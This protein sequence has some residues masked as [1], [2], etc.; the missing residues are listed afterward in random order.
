MEYHPDFFFIFKLNTKYSPVC[1]EGPVS[2]STS[3][4]VSTLWSSSVVWI[5]HP[6]KQR[7]KKNFSVVYSISIFY[8]DLCVADIFKRKTLWH[9]CHWHAKIWRHLIFSENQTSAGN[10]SKCQESS[11][12]SVPNKCLHW[13]LGHA[14]QLSFSCL[15][16]KIFF[17]L[18]ISHTR[19]T[20]IRVQ[21]D[22]SQGSR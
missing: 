13:S 12:S 2:D 17:D 1:L 6:F 3:S 8:I 9:S 14:E 11:E 22:G 18:I 7:G 16:S 21:R 20:D 10:Q 15:C 19:A 5:F 4:F